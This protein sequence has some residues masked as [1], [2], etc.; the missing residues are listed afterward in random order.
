V[1]FITIG[2][3]ANCETVA[4]NPG[5]C[6]ANHGH[7]GTC[8]IAILPFGGNPN[9]NQV[10][11]YTPSP[12][13]SSLVG[14]TPEVELTFDGTATGSFDTPQTI[15]VSWD[16]DITNNHPGRTV[17]WTL[18]IEILTSG[19][20][21]GDTFTG[22][23][24]SSAN[25]QEVSGFSA[26]SGVFG[27]VTGWEIQLTA[28]GSAASDS[29]SLDIPGGATVNINPVVPEPAS[30]FLAAGGAALLLLRRKLSRD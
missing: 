29:F 11:V 1:L 8:T 6:T 22:S 5:A 30:L 7:G 9:A 23:V 3:V 26:I 27:T 19:P 2:G 13:D 14:G 4:F 15:P 20:T 17:S 25:P 10:E 16:F 21:Y 12:Y 18:L 28:L 24:G